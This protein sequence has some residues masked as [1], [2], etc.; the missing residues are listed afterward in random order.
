MNIWLT[1]SISRK[2]ASLTDVGNDYRPWYY[3][4]VAAY[5]NYVALGV[6]EV[7][8]TVALG[9][10]TVTE[11]TG[12]IKEVSGSSTQVGSNRLVVK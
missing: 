8:T 12:E 7:N 2:I 1:K 5:E 9:S 10:T 4:S 6:T 11:I 3:Q